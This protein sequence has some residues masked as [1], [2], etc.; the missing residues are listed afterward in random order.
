MNILAAILLVAL[1]GLSMGAT[2]AQL[3]ITHLLRDIYLKGNIVRISYDIELLNNGPVATKKYLHLVH[4]NYTDKLMEVLAFTPGYV[5]LP[6]AKQSS[7][8]GNNSDAYK[9]ELPYAM[10]VGAKMKI[11]VLELYK[12]RLAPKPEKLPLSYVFITHHTVR[13]NK[14]LNSL[15]ISTSFLPTKFNHRR[16]F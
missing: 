7:S 4:K 2:E 3:E 16:P 8:V 9:V 12:S 1:F 6:I 14:R 5:E 13:K 15:I 10:Q 11:R